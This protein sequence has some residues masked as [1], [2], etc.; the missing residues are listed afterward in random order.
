[1]ANIIS[2]DPWHVLREMNQFLENSLNRNQLSTDTSKVETSRWLPAVDIKEEDNRFVLLADIPG[3]DPNDIQLT[4]D[5]NMLVIK[6]NKQEVKK[7]QKDNYYRVE[8]MQGEFYRQFNL[9][10]TADCEQIQAKSKHG[11]LE[12]IIPK[13]KA[14]KARKINIDTAH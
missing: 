10:D 4:T 3:V 11:V 12:V 8:R 5:K 13:R 6:G 9:P 14:E 7:E 1:M 2:Y